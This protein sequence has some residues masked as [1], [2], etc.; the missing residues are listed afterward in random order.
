PAPPAAPPAA[1]A[2][3]AAP[4]APPAAPAADK[5]SRSAKGFTLFIDV[6]KVGGASSVQL[7]EVFAKYSAE[8]LADWLQRNP[9]KTDAAGRPV[10]SFY[11]IP[12][13]E[14]RDGLAS[15]A[16]VIVTL[17]KFGTRDV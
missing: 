3:P 7:D 15:A 16:G 11:Q 6:A 4:F 13:F 14:R 9:G 10:A 1:P 8:F 5:K 17:E 2:A 12:F